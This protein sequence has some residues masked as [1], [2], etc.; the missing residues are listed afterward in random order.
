MNLSNIFISCSNIDV[1]K[2]V[3]LYND[4]EAYYSVDVY[5]IA[6]KDNFFKLPR[7]YHFTYVEKFCIHNGQLVALI[8]NESM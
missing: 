4:I 1:S 5:K 7:K 3:I 6:I 2:P 8:S